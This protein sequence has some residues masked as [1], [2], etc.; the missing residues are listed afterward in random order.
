[1]RKD[2]ERFILGRYFTFKKKKEKLE[3]LLAPVT[4]LQNTGIDPA[5][6]E[7]MET[8]KLDALRTPII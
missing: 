6:W 4:E 8:R 5:T 7:T 2:K 3:N 1:M